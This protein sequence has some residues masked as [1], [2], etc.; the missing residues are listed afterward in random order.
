MKLVHSTVENVGGFR[1]TNLSIQRS[2]FL[3]SITQQH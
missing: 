3:F 2:I 1:T